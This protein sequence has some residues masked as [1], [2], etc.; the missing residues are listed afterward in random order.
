MGCVA[1]AVPKHTQPQAS[2][3]LGTGTRR[4]R[5]SDE[6]KEKCAQ[7]YAPVG[8][9]CTS[10]HTLATTTKGITAARHA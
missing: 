6:R 3:E 9:L 8:E 2:E 10:G 4:T 5:H 1:R 7:Q